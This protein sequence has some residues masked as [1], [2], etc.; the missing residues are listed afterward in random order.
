MAARQEAGPEPKRTPMKFMLL[1]YDEESFFP[2]LSDKEVGDLM[3]AFHR[4]TAALTEAGV[5]VAGHRLSPV[6]TATTLRT[7]G[8]DIAVIDGPFAETKEQLGGFYMIEVPDL[9]TAIKWAR[10]CPGH[11]YGAVEVRPVMENPD[12]A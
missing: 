6:A 7:N 9:D 3:A 5:Y 4:Y 12:A 10:Q 2:Q 1:I 11:R 8:A